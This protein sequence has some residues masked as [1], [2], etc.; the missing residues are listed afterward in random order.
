MALFKDYATRAAE[1]EAKRAEEQLAVDER[2]RSLENIRQES[3]KEDM[4]QNGLLFDDYDDELLVEKIK[5]N[6]VRL[7]DDVAFGGLSNTDL[8]LNQKPAPPTVESLLDVITR[9]NWIIIQQ[10]ERIARLLEER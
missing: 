6:I 2:N 8:M 1:K 5:A 7:S 3:L 4:D 9:Q 10:N